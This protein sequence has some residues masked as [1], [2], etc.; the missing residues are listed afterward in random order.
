MVI[1][2]KKDIQ[3]EILATLEFVHKPGIIF[4]I[5]YMYMYLPGVSPGLSK[6]RFKSLFM[7]SQARR[8]NTPWGGLE[9]LKASS[10]FCAFW[11]KL[12][13]ILAVVKST[14]SAVVSQAQ[15]I[16]LFAKV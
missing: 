11:A 4:F 7:M 13:A 2:I 3:L 6:G 8:I 10:S 16:I 15:R 1:G 5:M 12:R 14:Y 9:N